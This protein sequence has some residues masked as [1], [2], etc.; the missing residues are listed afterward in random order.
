MIEFE[1]GRVIM[2]YYKHHVK[3]MYTIR[4]ICVGM[5]LKSLIVLC[6]F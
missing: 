3:T 5:R 4:T 2:L 6:S 1:I